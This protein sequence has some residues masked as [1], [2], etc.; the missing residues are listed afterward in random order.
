MR[1][2]SRSGSTQSFL[3]WP[4]KAAEGCRSPRRFA[5]HAAHETTRRVLECSSPSAF[6]ARQ[7]AASARRRLEL[8]HAHPNEAQCGRHRNRHGLRRQSGSGDGAFGRTR[9]LEN[10]E[11]VPCVRKRCRAALATAVQ[12]TLGWAEIF[13]NCA[14]EF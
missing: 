14:R 11:S 7:S 5:R 4:S 2:Q 13:A 6:A 12:D 1:N 9:R 10:F 8:S 3:R